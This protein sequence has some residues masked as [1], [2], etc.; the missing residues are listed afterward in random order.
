MVKYGFIGCGNMGGAIAKALRKATDQIVITDR[1]GKARS[2]AAELGCEYN[3]TDAI[4]SSCD[5]IFLAVKPQMMADVLTPLKNKLAVKKPLLISIAAGLSIERLEEMAGSDIPMIRMMPNT[6]VSVGCGMIQYCCNPLVEPSVLKSFLSDMRFCGKLD[7]I[8]EELMD[9]ASAISGSGPAYMYLFAEA[10]ADGAA[11]CGLSRE[12]ALE[13]AIATM[14][15]AAEMLNKSGQSPKTLREA[16]CSPGGSTLAGLR[17][18]DEN[19]FADAVAACIRA[20]YA[21]NKEL[22][23]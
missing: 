1:S 11:A 8:D 16:V 17:A 23:K 21:R 19:G 4:I 10:L 3:D 2:L 14:T 15:G 13:Y 6:P 7:L 22:G 12:K 9:C 5:R 20:A 18:L